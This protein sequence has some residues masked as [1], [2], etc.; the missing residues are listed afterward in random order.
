MREQSGNFD[1]L[2]SSDSAKSLR[3]GLIGSGFMARKHLEILSLIQRETHLD[4][5]GLAGR[6]S[7]T[8]SSLSQEFG[9]EFTTEAISDLLIQGQLTHLIVAV[10]EDSL[11]QVCLDLYSFRGSILFEKPFG[12][13]LSESRTLYDQFD[14]PDNKFVGFN[15]RFYDEAEHIKRQIMATSNSVVGIF[16]DQH[17]IDEARELGISE[18]IL[19]SW[20]YANAI[21][22]IDLMNFYLRG[23]PVSVQTNLDFVRGNGRFLLSAIEFDSGD[24]GIYSSRWN[25]PGGWRVSLIIDDAEFV[26]APLETLMT[27]PRGARF[28]TPWLPDAS[29]PKEIKKGLY[30][31]M[32]AFLNFPSQPSNGLATIEE[33]LDV[34]KLVK[35]IFK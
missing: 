33:N 13:N 16:E 35:E 27:R 2:L 25:L 29:E 11:H 15:R 26:Q 12:L 17:D 8:V 34:M 23:K 20:E 5:I 6:N 4:F 9:I 28:Y 1:M 3:I 32:K 24:I 31:Q 30:G 19:E 22:I 10:N 14:Y 21:H 18:S 7:R